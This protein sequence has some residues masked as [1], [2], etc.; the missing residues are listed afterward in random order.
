MNAE[1]KNSFEKTINGIVLSDGDTKVVRWCL[2]ALARIGTR[3][4]S[5]KYV[6]AAMKQYE[7]VPEI[8]A[9]AVAA[10]SHMY[11]GSLEAVPELYS[12]DPS[13]RILAAMQTTDVR[14]LD[15][16]KLS[17][18]LDKADKEVLKLALLVVGLNKDI[19]NL[20]HPRYSNGTIVKQLGQHD[21]HIVRQYSVWSVME[22]KR[23][24]LSDLGIPFDEIGSQPVNVQ[25]KLLQ[26]AAER[27]GDLKVR[28]KII[29][30]GT[31][32][33]SSEAR[34][35]LAKGL[36]HSYY[37]GLE[38][39]TI[40]WFDV[41]EDYNVL[42]LIA[43]HFAR[44]SDECGSYFEKVLEVVEANPKLSER[45]L[46]GAEGKDLYR[47]IKGL[48]RAGGMRDLFGAPTTLSTMFQNSTGISRKAPP[49]K[50]LFLAANPV[51]QTPLKIDIEASNLKE[52][53]SLVRDAKVAV[54]VEHAWAIRTDKLQVEILNAKPEVLHFS[55]HGDTGKL[56]FEDR[57]GVSTEVSGD[58]LADLI[59]LI[60]NIKC[61]VLNACYSESI[62][63]IIA[64]HVEV[65]IG[66]DVSISDVAAIHFTQAFYRAIAHGLD[67]QRAFALAR[68]D[69]ELNNQKT[70]S[71]KYTIT[72]ID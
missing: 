58:T 51:D 43:E 1:S 52:Q 62:A 11:H 12:V 65:V 35:G 27:E 10:L 47:K 32:N 20:L 39:L 45:V 55:G 26:L 4:G 46:L 6:A 29:H 21:D 57:D 67:F 50:V 14:K 48:D 5:S 33:E 37:D 18:D 56:I 68:N 25:A 8:V 38:D 64:P 19:Q 59:K 69:L 53:L 24:S 66:C 71:L 31:F 13:I 23:L 28:H 34:I 30:E 49:M 42:A 2:N 22:N 63:Q 15:L 54:N 40:R 61:V 9:A 44:Y 36:A 60:P 7:E 17:I 70:E 72:R 16:S 3:Q 41:E